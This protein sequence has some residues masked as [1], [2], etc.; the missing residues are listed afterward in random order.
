[1]GKNNYLFMTVILL[2]NLE[3]AMTD[4]SGHQLYQITH[5]AQ[6]TIT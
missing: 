5:L 2:I 4:M 1:L 3:S 6:L